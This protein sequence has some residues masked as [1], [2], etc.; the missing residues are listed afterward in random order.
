[1]CVSELVRGDMQP[2]QKMPE[3]VI[4]RRIAGVEITIDRQRILGIVRRDCE[5]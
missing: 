2:Q 1:M 3:L 4:L 5:R